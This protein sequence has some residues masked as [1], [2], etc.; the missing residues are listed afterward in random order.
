[1]GLRPGVS[2]M[3]GAIALTFIATVASADQ[4][5]CV[6]D[7]ATGFTYNKMTKHWDST[8]FNT[9]MKYVVAP[10]KPG[11]SAAYKWNPNAAAAEANTRAA[12][13]ETEAAAANLRAAEIMKATA[14]RQ[15]RQ[16][17]ITVLSEAFQKKPGRVEVAWI[18]NDSESM[19][20]AIQL[21]NILAA[22]SWQI[23]TSSRAYGDRL[24][25]GIQIPKNSGSKEDDEFLIETFKSIGIAVTTDDLPVP[26]MSLGSGAPHPDFS[27]ILIGSRRPTFSQPPD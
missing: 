1:M 24:L 27:T 12:N 23:T 19:G 11:E 14:W 17:Q 20:L 16:E 9:D 18:S 7:K 22:A 26:P 10:A 13:L 2:I 6:P 15:F 25:W 4:Y 5:I 8:N 3:I 21:I